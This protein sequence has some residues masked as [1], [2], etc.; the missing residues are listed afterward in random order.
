MFS[1]AK[2]VILDLLRVRV[3]H[4]VIVAIH[5]VTVRINQ[6]EGGIL[7]RIGNSHRT[8]RRADPAQHE[9]FRS[10]AIG[11]KLSDDH[12]IAKLAIGA[13]RD[14]Q[15]RAGGLRERCDGQ[16]SQ[17]REKSA[18][19][20]HGFELSRFRYGIAERF[21][22]ERVASSE[23]SDKD[24]LLTRTIAMSPPADGPG[25]KICSWGAQIGATA[26]CTCTIAGRGG[27]RDG[28]GVILNL[29]Y[30]KKM[31]Q[32]LSPRSRVENNLF[33]TA[34]ARK[35]REIKPSMWRGPIMVVAGAE[36]PPIVT[37]PLARHSRQI[38]TRSGRS[39]NPTEVSFSSRSKIWN[40]DAIAVICDKVRRPADVAKWQ[41]QRT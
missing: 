25:Q 30:R 18:D 23:V 14:T 17:D 36:L 13:S 35:E 38:R 32:S 19:E 41:T 40:S 24:E 27:S 28:R 9:G 15:D 12:G 16:K 3:I 34:R 11:D 29:D 7:E 5:P 21:S 1:G 8:E 6:A 37:L 22:A 26:G 20:V 33:P 31:I 4:P 2:V 10:M 39:H